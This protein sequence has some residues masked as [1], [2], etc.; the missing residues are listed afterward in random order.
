M[1]RPADKNY[2]WVV[3][4]LL[5]IAY[6]LLQGMRQVY[7]ASLPQIRLDFSSLGVTATSLGLVG[8]VFYFVYGLCAPC[9]SVV[10]DVFRRK[11]VIVLGC[12]L[13]SV[14]IFLSGFTSTLGLII[15]TYGVINA[16]GQSMVP[17][18]SSAV[19]S[20]YHEESR[21]TALSI[22]QVA[23]YAGIILS[24]LL[25]G[26]VGSL[27]SG[28]WR[29]AFW[30]LGGF[31]LVWTVVL[32][33]FLREKRETSA[34]SAQAADEGPSARAAVL[35]FFRSPAAILLTL[36]FAMTMYGDNGYKVWMTTYLKDAFAETTPASAAFHAVFWFYVGA[37]LGISAAG[38]ISDRLSRR[39][40]STR[41]WTAAVGLGLSAP[42]VLLTVKGGS[43]AGTCVAL[44]LW[45]FARGIYD[46]NFFAS[47]YDVVE[48]RYRAA[49]TGLFCC[50]GFVIGSF[51]PTVLGWISERHSMSIG[52]SS[53][54][55]FYLLGA[56]FVVA[57]LVA[58]GRES[59][60]LSAKRPRRPSGR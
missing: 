52:L 54:G 43:L 18:S 13:L 53:L 5:W 17:S 46:S 36:G 56:L 44:G 38:R 55:G 30:G 51:A 35:S 1:S 8:T 31:G 59:R 3:L 47:L 12:L 28:M 10:A 4:G 22:Y 26:W 27:G 9:A 57:A 41:F 58:F 25:A 37:F 16:L 48:P 6:F 15:V 20:E 42:C 50:G 29:W 39:F 24:S 49:A 21:S 40:A 60:S 33:V 7:N 11:T 14:G 2:K 32:L 23:N 45:G 34:P 19:I